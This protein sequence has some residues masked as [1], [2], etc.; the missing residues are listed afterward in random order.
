MTTGG[1]PAILK[2]LYESYLIN[3]KNNMKGFKGIPIRTV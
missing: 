1:F 3:E 2:D